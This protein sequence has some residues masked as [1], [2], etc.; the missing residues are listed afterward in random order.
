VPQCG[1]RIRPKAIIFDYGN[2]LCRPQDAS[3]VAAMAAVLHLPRDRFEEI[4]W[5]HRLAY[6]EG[7]LDPAEYWKFFGSVTP[8]QIEQL[9]RL[10]GVSW[11]HADAVMTEW[12]GQ[13]RVA[14]F[15]TALLSNMPFTVRDAVLACEWL[16]EFDQRTFSCELRISKPASEIYEHCLRGLGV[17]AKDALFLD[18][19]PSNVQGAEA[20]GMQGILFTSAAD[21]AHLLAGRFALLVPGAATLE[22]GDEKD[23]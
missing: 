16:P 22:T 18:D 1:L 13:L 9:N 15:R 4:Y 17:A 23:Q 6:D 2:V 11:T 14:G 20:V 8:E 7:K 19:R 12:A 5:R 10:D 3:D 21:L